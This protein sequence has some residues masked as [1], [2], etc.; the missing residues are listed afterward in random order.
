MDD[1]DWEAFGVD[2]A[3]H[4]D[5]AILAFE[6][7]KETKGDDYARA[8]FAEPLIQARMDYEAAKAMAH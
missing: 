3:D 2:A 7:A 1:I 6:T 4:Y 5:A 8:H